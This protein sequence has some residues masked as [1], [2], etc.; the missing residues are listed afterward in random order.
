MTD[1]TGQPLPDPIFEPSPAEEV[2]D[3]LQFHLDM[4]VRDL[5]AQGYD[6]D[7][8]ERLAREEFRDGARVAAECRQLA[9]DREQSVRRTRYLSNLVQDVGY[10]FRMLRK[11]MGFALLTIVPLALG[12]GAATA[13][14][15]VADG[16]ML[17]QL[18]FVHPEQLVAIW[19]V[20]ESIHHQS[21]ISLPWNSIVIGQ[22]D[23]QALH[24]QAHTLS[25]VAA[26]QSDNGMLADASGAVTSVG[27]VRV[28]S[29]I[30]GLL[31]VRPV[32]GRAFLPGEDAVGGPRIALLSWEAWQHDFGGDSAV[33]GRSITFDDN[34]Y[35][36]VGVMP[37]AVR[38]DRSVPTPAIWLPAFQGKYD[39][40]SQHNRSYRGLG[41]LA[42]GVTTAQASAD[43][44]RIL[45]AVKVGW[46]GTAGGT[47]GR[48]ANWQDDQVGSVRGSLLILAGAVGL[49]LLIACVNVATV[50]FGEAARRQPEIAART[51]L[52]ATPGRLVRQ[53]LTESVMIAGCGTIAG[54]PLGWAITRALV[55]LAPGKIPGLSDVRYDGRVFLFAAA[56]AL[57][58]GIAFGV[59][60]TLALLRWGSHS[61][62]RVGAGQ[63]ARGEHRIQRALVAI[64]VGL[65]LVMLI[66]CS[67]LGRSLVR[68]MSVDPGFA[69]NG[70]I[71]VYL[72]A[73]SRIWGD[74]ATDVAYQTTALRELAAIPGVG[75]VSGANSP[76]YSGG[77]SGSPIR[78]VGQ[79]DN[80]DA[81]PR[82][83][84]QRVVLPG[85]LHTLRVPLVAGRDFSPTDNAGSEPVAIVSAA[86]AQ[87]DFA[88][89]QA[90]GA[91]V[92]WQGHQWTI[93]GVA[94][95]VHYTGLAKE[96][97]P[98]IYIP[99]AQ[100]PGSWMSY[101]MRASGASDGAA[102]MRN[103]RARLAAIN[104]A[105]TVS[106]V[107]PVPT[108]VEHSYAEEK[109]RTLLG[110]LFGI[111]GCL[112]SAVGIFGVISRTVARRRRE[113]GIRLAL[114]SSMRSLTTLMLRETAVGAAIG[115]AAGIV[116]AMWLGRALAPYLFGV[117][118]ADPAAYLLAIAVLAAQTGIAAVIPAR[119][120]A[121]V[122]PVTVLRAE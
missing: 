59:L 6:R 54:L 81:P 105:V 107:D 3:E 48:A 79:E 120:A 17:R 111:I 20:E 33:I 69:P 122:D 30:F 45:T 47:S 4:R 29:S 86:E 70:L 78:I 99:D 32:V 97:Q 16:V 44:A 64:E 106:T 19:A 100:W 72:S 56:C 101:L 46:K 95:D 60:P 112:L 88:G 94:A 8:A 42:R 76:I 39:A 121:R 113:A 77:G 25:A 53:L 119:R 82:D 58:T 36:V 96:F 103:I 75:S 61:T 49:L 31:G 15:S 68:L 57:V 67:L 23:Y 85:Y 87:R 12:I 11:R 102:L 93:I 62:V 21:A 5:L 116:A 40:P 41:R 71:Q 74:S 66:G 35:T 65:S 22:G 98:S 80:P 91:R 24:D 55:A 117:R 7:A 27:G 114:G 115:A 84:Q 104:P 63:T 1:S 52:G 34:P 2:R 73:P 13:M 51:A 9:T 83:V 18:P 43:V 92:I 110:S 50:M 14:Y 118:P 89:T 109:Y 90:V 37:P 10:A 38:L 108:L 26:W 28:T